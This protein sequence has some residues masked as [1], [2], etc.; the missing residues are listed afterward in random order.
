LAPGDFPIVIQGPSGTGKEIVANSIHNNSKRK[1][2]PMVTINCAA[3]PKDLEEAQFFGHTRGAFTGAYSARNGIMAAADN[4]TLFLDE[5]SEL[6]L[7]VQAKLLRVLEN[8]EFLRI[9]ETTSRKVDIRLITA[10][11]RN[12]KEMVEKGSFRDDLFFRLGFLINTK[13][14]NEHREDIPLIAK[15]FININNTNDPRCPKQITAEALS[16]LV[17]YNWRGNVR[18]LKQALNLLCHI[19]MGKKRI[20]ISDVQS[21]LNHKECKING[22]EL[23]STEKIKILREFEIDYFTRLLKKYCGNM[24][25]AAKASGMHRPNLIKKLKNLDISPSDFK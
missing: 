18:E 10:T 3:I 13:P 5:V 16:Y 9:G 17:D 4:T 15:H 14:L 6:S 22:Y 25:Q 11:N 12:I 19:A 7:G 8:G 24:T 2:N 21:I 23:Y 1:K 20:N